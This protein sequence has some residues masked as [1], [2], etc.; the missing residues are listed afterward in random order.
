MKTFNIVVPLNG[1]DTLNLDITTQLNSPEIRGAIGRF[2]YVHLLH[3]S[4][5]KLVKEMEPVNL[6]TQSVNYREAVELLD[7][8]EHL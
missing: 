8:L 5:K 3:D 1:R 4:L 2:N 6:I 7:V